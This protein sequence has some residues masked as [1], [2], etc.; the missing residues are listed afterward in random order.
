VRIQCLF[1][2]SGSQM[3]NRVC[4]SDRCREETCGLSQNIPPIMDNKRNVPT[5]LCSRGKNRQH[6]PK[7]TP[8]LDR[9]AT[10]QHRCHNVPVSLSDMDLWV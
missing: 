4:V 6:P 9:V 5:R 7:R 8:Q 2:H 3:T 1:Q 10:A